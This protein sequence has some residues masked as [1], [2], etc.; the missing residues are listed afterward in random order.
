MVS[1]LPDARLIGAPAMEPPDRLRPH[2][3]D[4][5]SHDA[6]VIDLGSAVAGLQAE[7]HHAIAGHRQVALGRQGPVTL[8]L[9]V[10]E[11]GGALKEHH[12]EG[13]VTIH[14]LTGHLEV[15]LG[16]QRSELRKGQLLILPPRLRHAVRALEPS[17]LLVSI[18]KISDDS[19]A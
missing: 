3:S 14:A 10:F 15:D 2:P 1:I 5:W 12:A 19:P 13:V 4:R 16:D 9:F 11:T 8:L 6:T 18:H 7:D 17:E